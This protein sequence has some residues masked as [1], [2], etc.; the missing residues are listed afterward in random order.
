[1]TRCL[2]PLLLCYLIASC[3]TR[4]GPP[5]VF[6][7]GNTIPAGCRIEYYAQ[8]HDDTWKRTLTQD[9]LPR[10]MPVKEAEK[11]ALS[12]AQ[13]RLGNEWKD[14]SIRVIP[15][16]STGAPV[17]VWRRNLTLQF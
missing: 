5:P 1:M 9:R 3:A 15:P 10:P 16:S 8:I 11:W 4:Q 2:L 7:I 13:Q 6:R 12:A 14:Y 17:V